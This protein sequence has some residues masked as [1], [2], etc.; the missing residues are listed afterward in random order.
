MSPNEKKDCKKILP[1]FTDESESKK[2]SFLSW[3]I[4]EVEFCWLEVVLMC[5]LFW[6]CWNSKVG[7]SLSSHSETLSNLSNLDDSSISTFFTINF[8]VLLLV[9]MFNRSLSSRVTECAGNIL[10]LGLIKCFKLNFP[11]ICVS[12]DEKINT[13]KKIIDPPGN[14][15][16]WMADLN[17]KDSWLAIIPFHDLFSTQSASINPGKVPHTFLY[18]TQSLTNPVHEW[19]GCGCAVLWSEV[20]C[21]LA[22]STVASRL[23]YYSRS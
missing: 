20:D 14:E 10:Y 19:L 18:K 13:Q 23:L 15:G 11:K 7:A 5:A 4:L 21:C 1:V 9:S 6:C 22:Q 3:L 17:Q 12:S 16:R 8:V 2:S